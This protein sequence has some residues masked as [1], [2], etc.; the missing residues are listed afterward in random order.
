MDFGCLT[1]DGL[2]DTGTL[3]NTISRRF[4]NIKQIASQKVLNQNSPPVFQNMVVNG[5]LEL[6]FETTELQHEAVEIMFVRKF[7]VKANSGNI[8]FGLLFLQR[9]GTLFDKKQ[10]TLNFLS[11]FMQLKNGCI[12]LRTRIHMSWNLC[13]THKKLFCCP[14]NKP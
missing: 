12:H 8:L 3:L 1:I 5:H 10:E 11:F 13:L 7:I 6:P 4:R 2:I 9:N 14:V